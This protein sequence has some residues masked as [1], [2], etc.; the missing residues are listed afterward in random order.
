MLTT[1]V[2]DSAGNI[3]FLDKQTLGMV[4][5]LSY[6]DYKK[7]SACIKFFKEYSKAID[8]LKANPKHKKILISPCANIGEGY[9]K[10]NWLYNLKH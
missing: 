6:F 8:Y 7:Q 10:N 3:Y 5:K 2:K 9:S 4:Q 1:K